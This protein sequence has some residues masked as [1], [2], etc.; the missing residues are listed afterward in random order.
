MRAQ[1]LASLRLMLN[2]GTRLVLIKNVNDKY[3]MQFIE[4]ILKE[5]ISRKKHKWVRESVV[6]S[7][8]S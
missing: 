2:N 6:E 8:V 5:K 4:R 7:V 1:T 3:S